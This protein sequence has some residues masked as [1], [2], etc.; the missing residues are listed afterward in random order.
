MAASKPDCLSFTS[1]TGIKRAGWM[2]DF[3]HATARQAES[4]VTAA[5][6][7]T[8]RLDCKPEG[9]GGSNG[10]EQPSDLFPVLRV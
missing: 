10:R 1:T 9:L 3:S 6:K 8:R 5:N 2:S 4:S 7:L